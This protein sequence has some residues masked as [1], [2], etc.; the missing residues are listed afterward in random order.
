MVFTMLMES[1]VPMLVTIFQMQQLVIVCDWNDSNLDLKRN[2][3]RDTHTVKLI[4][5]LSHVDKKV[6]IDSN[7]IL[8]ASTIGKE[9]ITA[10][11]KE[12]FARNYPS[13]IVHHKDDE[14]FLPSSGINQQVYFYNE[15]TGS[16]Y[17]KYWVNSVI[18]TRQLDLRHRLDD[19]YQR[20]SDMH[21]LNL[22][23]AVNP[24]E[25]I[26]GVRRENT[27]IT[28]MPSGDKFFRWSKD[29]TFGMLEDFLTI[30]GSE[31][32]FTIR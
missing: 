1:V 9:E 14:V 12:T 19:V 4:K 11:M 10:I 17:E 7:L 3:F 32:N 5:S 2:L 27:D 13:V 28:T 26:Y 23:I 31:L 18:V 22:N 20:R 24:W 16:L 25:Q 6:L 29:E 15:D 30:M 21:G 8:C